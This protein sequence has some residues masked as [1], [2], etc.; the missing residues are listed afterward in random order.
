VKTAAQLKAKS[1]NL[2][3]QS[4]TPPHIIQRNFL[5]ERFLERASLSEYRD[6]FIIKGGMLLTSLIGLDLRATMDLDATLKGRDLDEAEVRAI[7]T[8]IISIPLDDSTQFAFSEIERTRVESDYPGWRISLDTN[9]DGIRDK[10]KLDITIGDVI[11]PRA[12]EYSY[13]LMFEDRSI[14]V[15]AYN[16]ETILA[17]KYA[18]CISLG[19]SNTRMKDYYDIYILTKL[20]GGEISKEV[21][22]EALRRTAEQRHIPLAESRLVISKIGSSPDMQK[23]WKRYQADAK[24]AAGIDFAD[25]AVALRTLGEWSGLIA[26]TG[27]VERRPKNLLADLAEAKQIVAERKAAQDSNAPSKDSNIDI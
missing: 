17:E 9:F 13:K 11:T 1:R 19:V 26:A 3:A 5:F 2:A 16:L 8:E 15:L 6:S 7:M 21:L 10:L 18:A 27:Q 24:Y 4:G 14:N 22:A 12:I 25:T 23:F 20:R